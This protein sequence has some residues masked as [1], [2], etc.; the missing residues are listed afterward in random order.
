[1]TNKS[2]FP[3]GIADLF[4]FVVPAHAGIQFHPSNQAFKQLIGRTSWMFALAG[5][6]VNLMGSDTISPFH[7]VSTFLPQQKPPHLLPELRMQ[8]NVV[9]VCPGEQ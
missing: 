6:R 2:A 8:Q 9:M 4:G 3:K 7:P 5:M 1:M